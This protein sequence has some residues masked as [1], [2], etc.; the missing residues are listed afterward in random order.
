[1]A[2]RRQLISVGIDIQNAATNGIFPIFTHSLCAPKA[3]T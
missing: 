1:M 2:E 3:I